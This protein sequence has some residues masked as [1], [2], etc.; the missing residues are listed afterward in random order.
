MYS[1]QSLYLFMK[2]SFA[3]K[4]TLRSRSRL[5]IQYESSVNMFGIFDRRNLTSIGEQWRVLVIPFSKRNPIGR[6]ERK[7]V[8][9][10]VFWT[11]SYSYINMMLHIKQE[12]SKDHPMNEVDRIISSTEEKR[13]KP[14]LHG[15]FL[16]LP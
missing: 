11:F 9:V 2:F 6:W 10:R 14:H 12:V 1:L 8:T 5:A 15:R 16:F 13:K 7:Y 4:T 3:M